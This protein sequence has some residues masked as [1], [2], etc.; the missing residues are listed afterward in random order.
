MIIKKNEVEK[1]LTV[2]ELKLFGHDNQENPN[3]PPVLRIMNVFSEA[4]AQ[5]YF[6]EESVLLRESYQ[7]LKSKGYYYNEE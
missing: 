1:A 4:Y 2:M 7:L 6:P 5:N 3:L